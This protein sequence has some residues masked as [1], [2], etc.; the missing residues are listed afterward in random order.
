MLPVADICPEVV[1][2][3][4]RILPVAVTTPAVLMFPPVMLATA[5]TVL[6]LT[7]PVT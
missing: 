3:P 1:T 7:P 2:L 4:P 5:V 6:P